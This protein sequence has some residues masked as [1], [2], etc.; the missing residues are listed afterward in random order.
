MKIFII[1]SKGGVGKSYLTKL[2]S[3][4]A[5]KDE[6]KTYFIDCDNASASTTKFFKGIE[7]RKSPYILFKSENLLGVDKKIDRTKFDTFLSTVE[8]LENVI[9]DFGAASSEQL[10][11]YIQE[12]SKNDILETL[13]EIGVN[14]FLV[15][16]GGGSI[17]ESIEFALELKKIK[18]V[19]K[20]VTVVANEYLGGVNGNSVREY[21]KAD[22]QI[23]S[24]HEDTNS[25]AQKEWNDLMN[26]GVVYS[27]IQSMTVIRKKRIV[28]Y[29]DSIFNQISA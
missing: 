14:L 8:K 28:S 1:Q 6:I 4:K 22:V 19:E 21:S 3:L 23:T 11:Y 13:Q 24:L 18:G 27:D 26:S 7:E 9:V 25:E 29:L 20:L 17:K 2:L 16:A 15:V 12:E 5:D 10:L